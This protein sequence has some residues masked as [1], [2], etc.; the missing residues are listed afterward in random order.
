[1]H[2]MFGDVNGVYV[3]VRWSDAYIFSLLR[4]YLLYH[5]RV[6][7]LIVAIL[8]VV[9]SSILQHVEIFS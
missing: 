5:E 3:V 1:M 7:C 4:Q 6:T 8:Q 2:Q 9:I